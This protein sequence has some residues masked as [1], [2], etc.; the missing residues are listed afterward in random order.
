MEFIAMNSPGHLHGRMPEAQ[1]RQTTRFGARIWAL[2][3]AFLWCGCIPVRSPTAVQ[4]FHPFPSGNRVFVCCGT[5]KSQRFDGQLALLGYEL[6]T[7]AERGATVLVELTAYKTTLPSTLATNAL[8][9]LTRSKHGGLVLFGEDAS[10]SITEDTP[11]NRELWAQKGK[12]H[13]FVQKR[14]AWIDRDTAG[15]LAIRAMELC[16][17]RE[18]YR[19]RFVRYELGWLV[20]IEPRAKE[21]HIGANSTVF[22]GDDGKVNC[23]LPGF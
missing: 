15:A 3:C 22:V 5:L 9:L 16:A 10:W 13:R 12:E 1:Q 8:L 20:A 14:S 2:V 7:Q 19:L 4:L 6:K 21:W 23:V 17:H 11:L 18:S